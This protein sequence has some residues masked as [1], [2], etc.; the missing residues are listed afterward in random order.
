[1]EAFQKKCRE[2]KLKITPQRTAIYR[3]LM[4][5]LDH[6][7]ADVVLKRVRKEI[8]NISFD[9]VNRTLL[10]FSAMGLINVV[11]NHSG[12]KRFDP[13]LDNHHHFQ[14]MRCN[15]IID[16]IDEQYDK[17]GAP[18]KLDRRLK[19]LHKKVVLEGICDRCSQKKPEV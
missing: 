4:K 17:I 19:V 2:Y 8:P 11:A 7:S 6:P 10:S 16:F 3:E 18:R 15:R 14:C 12:A 5:T 9:T 1:M 13:V